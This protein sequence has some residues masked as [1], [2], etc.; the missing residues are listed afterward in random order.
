MATEDFG[1]AMAEAQAAG[2]PVIAYYKGG[3]S[4]IIKDGETG[5]LFKEQTSVSLIEAV[6]KFESMKLNSKAASDNAAHFS[7]ERFRDEFSN[8]VR[9]R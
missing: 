1:I 9:A 8:F 6:R 5:L 7:S 3:A 4:E 2:C